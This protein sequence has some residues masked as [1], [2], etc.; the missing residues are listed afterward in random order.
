MNRMIRSLAL[1]LLSSAVALA[2]ETDRG[3][4]PTRGASP[5]VDT[6]AHEWL[7]SRQKHGDYEKSTF[8]FEHGLRDDPEHAVT[9]NDWD[10][11]FDNSAA[12]RPDMFGV[13][14]VRDDISLFADLG[15]L[16]FADVDPAK[17]AEVRMLDELE[18]FVGHLYVVHTMD[19]ETNRWAFFRVIVHHSN[20]SVRIE[21]LALDPQGLRSS[22][23]LEFEPALEKKLRLYV[24]TLDGLGGLRFCR[25]D[26]ETSSERVFDLLERDERKDLPREFGGVLDKLAELPD[27]KVLLPKERGFDLAAVRAIPVPEDPRIRSLEAALEACSRAARLSWQVWDDGAVVLKRM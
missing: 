10:L 9:R 23:G 3:Q 14:M 20:D 21:W 16:G 7:L 5:T 8:S 17:A 11:Q 13:R 24:R 27:V 6:S 19:T 1:A 2:Q 22:P 18:C 4:E 12:A 25:R 15:E 26:S